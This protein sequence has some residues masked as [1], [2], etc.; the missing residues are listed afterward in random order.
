M[1]QVHQAGATQ[2]PHTQTQTHGHAGMSPSHTHPRIL[3]QTP[4][5]SEWDAAGPDTPSQA[6]RA[7]ASHG[8]REWQAPNSPKA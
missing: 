7:P 1:L 2:G 8:G 3:G 6:S 5:E 4:Q